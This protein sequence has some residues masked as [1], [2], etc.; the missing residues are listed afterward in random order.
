[1]AA[2]TEIERLVV[3]IVGDD[4][5]YR[6]TMEGVKNYNEQLRQ[7]GT[8]DLA[9]DSLSDLN[10]EA[11]K[12]TQVLTQFDF[13]T[14]SFGRTLSMTGHLVSKFGMGIGLLNPEI[15]GVISQLGVL[16][17]MSGQTLHTLARISEAMKGSSGSQAILTTTDLTA[18]AAASNLAAEQEAV[19][20]A[21]ADRILASRAN[22]AASLASSAAE[23]ELAS[24]SLAANVSTEALTVTASQSI[25]T[26]AAYSATVS[27]ATAAITAEQAAARAATLATPVNEAMMT[28]AAKVITLTSAEANSA[29][30]AGA[31]MADLGV[32]TSALVVPLTLLA[33]AASVGVSYIYSLGKASREA[34]AAE[35]KYQ[36]VLKEGQKISTSSVGGNWFMAE[37]RSIQETT[38]FARDQYEKRKDL[39]ATTLQA[40]MLLT[41]KHEKEKQELSKGTLAGDIFK[42]GWNLV[43]N[44]ETRTAS[45]ESQ[46]AA[47]RI[48]SLQETAAAKAHEI[49]VTTR[50]TKSLH[51]EQIAY[52]LASFS[53]RE[54][55]DNKNQ[56][57]SNLE[58]ALDVSMKM[59]VE[60][61]NARDEIERS[62]TMAKPGHELEEAFRSR[63]VPGEANSTRESIANKIAADLRVADAKNVEN[64]YRREVNLLNEKI[65]R[66]EML[67]V[68][69]ARQ[70]AHDRAVMEGK[71]ESQAAELG[72]LAGVQTLRE[73]T[74]RFSES[75]KRAAVEHEYFLSE[76]RA[77]ASPMD[78]ERQSAIEVSKAYALWAQANKDLVATEGDKQ[79]K[80]LETNA[81]QALVMKYVQ[82]GAAAQEKYKEPLDR[83]IESQARLKRS[84]ELG[85]FGEGIRG[86]KAYEK[87]LA[88]VYGQAH[89]EYTADFLGQ[90]FDAVLTNSSE[91]DRFM[92]EYTAGMTPIPLDQQGIPPKEE[93]NAVSRGIDRIVSGIK[94]LVSIEKS[95]GNNVVNVANLSK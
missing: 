14:G 49:E 58:K 92:R 28:G 25:P 79:R 47:D 35:E 60:A 62:R 23:T 77:A 3:R 95:R 11:A 18:A 78:I 6:T 76:V 8:S 12:T 9:G 44:W 42:G 90:Q 7:S 38:S 88:D 15:G 70:E 74:F 19:A 73:E 30:A 13:A 56:E 84:F 57:V 66:T 33:T 71:T 80:L 63:N 34:A 45:L 52:D 31:K 5:G 65:S 53:G 69:L 4:K 50:Y 68:I 17:S 20:L 91:Y 39:L 54:Y 10:Q 48:K 82:E 85:G 75:L 36:E 93:G 22:L 86:A 61:K 94:E 16:G 41:S 51:D 55:A 29:A 1:M 64:A 43:T 83:V 89:K 59:N 21:T 81:A 27:A 72:R 40:E 2:E 87:A 26:W 32:A 24:A 46:Q 67:G 37:R